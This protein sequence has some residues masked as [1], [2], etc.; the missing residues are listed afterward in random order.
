MAIYPLDLV[1]TRLQ[2]QERVRQDA[3]E[4]P[5]EKNNS[6]YAGVRDAVAKI[7]R[8]EGG[9]PAFYSGVAQDTFKSMADSFL[10][11]LA[12]NVLLRLRERRDAGAPTGS[13]VVATLEKIGVGCLAGALSKAVTTPLASVVVRKQTTAVASA[14]RTADGTPATLGRSLSTRDIA[15]QIYADKGPL[16]FWSG[17]PA[18]ILL[19]LNPS[20][21]FYAEAALKRAL[22]VGGEPGL[23]MAFLPAALA[24]AFASATM[25]PLSLAKARSQAAKG[26]GGAGGGGASSETAGRGPPRNVLASIPYIART[27]GVQ[28]LYA[29]IAGEVLKGFFAHGLTMLVKERIHSQVINLYMLLARLLRRLRVRLA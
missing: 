14:A 1:I 22:R 19:T 2:C 8:H 15:A 28:A 10:F 13:A 27:E 7:Y 23:L 9:L 16:G 3:S 21:T 26:G 25:Y 29:G 5:T 18:S 20:L 11:F 6:K 12:Y 17:Y 4:A 24:K